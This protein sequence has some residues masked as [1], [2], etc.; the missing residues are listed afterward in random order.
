MIEK[1][2]DLAKKAK[3]SL[4]FKKFIIFLILYLIEHDKIGRITTFHAS[5]KKLGQNE[6]DF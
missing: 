3:E 6:I 1:T 5:F 2:I 4:S